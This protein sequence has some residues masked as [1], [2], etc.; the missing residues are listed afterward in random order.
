MKISMNNLIIMFVVLL[1][2]ALFDNL[3]WAFP[4]QD[5]W[6]VLSMQLGIALVSISPIGS[7]ILR[8]LFGSRKPQTREELERLSVLFNEVYDEVKTQYP[9]IQK[10]INYYID[11]SLD[12]NAYAIGSNTI[13]VTKGSL[14]NLTDEELK[15]IL[16]HEFGHIVSGD[17]ALQS[18][19]L[20]GNTVF[21]IL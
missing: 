17:T 16:G 4:E 1:L 7:F 6:I 9:K 14:M 2:T 15:G 19:L 5:F 11:D 12:I 21:W 18:F 20:V 10:N 3:I 8:L 13:T